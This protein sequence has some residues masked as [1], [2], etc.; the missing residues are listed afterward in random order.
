MLPA[1][2]ELVAAMDQ[3]REVCSAASSLR[4][5]KKLRVRLPLPKLTVAVENPERLGPFTDLI[6]DELNVKEVE[7][8]DE[9]DHLRPL[10]ADRQRPGRRAAAGQGRAGRDQG[11]QGRRG[12]RQPG[13]HADRGPG[14]AATRGVQLAAGGRR[15]G[16]HRARC[17]AGPGW[18]C[19]TAR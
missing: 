19:W 14:G 13:R 15:P 4:K 18:W 1:D 3:V 6:A 17:P 11:G 12:R 9:I 5:A 2:A 7:L 8:T 16:V 10:R